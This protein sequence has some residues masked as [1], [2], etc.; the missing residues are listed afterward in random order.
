MSLKYE[1][2]LTCLLTQRNFFYRARCLFELLTKYQIINLESEIGKKSEIRLFPAQDLTSKWISKSTRHSLPLSREPC[3][4]KR[5]NEKEKDKKGNIILC[6][7]TVH[8]HLPGICPVSDS[9][10]TRNWVYWFRGNICCGIIKQE[11]QTYV[12]ED[13]I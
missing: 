4:E 2:Y 13:Q 7:C 8:D 1:Q 9:W 12:T 5:K 11:C 6:C 3:P 10:E